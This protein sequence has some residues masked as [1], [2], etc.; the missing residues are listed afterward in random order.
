MKCS[1]LKVTHATHVTSAYNPL[2]RTTLSNFKKGAMI[3][4]LPMGLE[5]EKQI[6]NVIR[7]YHNL[8]APGFFL[9][10]M[11]TTKLLSNIHVYILLECGKPLSYIKTVL[12]PTK[13]C[14]YEDTE[15]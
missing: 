5:K 13:M 6:T 11:Y 15:S 1:D 10:R 7:G 9:Y 14:V 8:S 3:D 4:N 2:A 12:F